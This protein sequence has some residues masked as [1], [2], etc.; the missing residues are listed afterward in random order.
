[1]PAGVGRNRGVEGISSQTPIVDL[2]SKV[3]PTYDRVGPRIFSHF[4]RRLVEMANMAGGAQVLDVATGR[5]A[6]LFPASDRVGPTGRV[7]GIDLVEGMVKETADEIELLGLKNAAMCQMDAEELK[8]PDAFF[9]VVLCGLSIFFFPRPE[10]ALS[11]FHR[12]MKTG[13]SVG[14]TT[15]AEERGGRGLSWMNEI[16]KPHLPQTE[17]QTGRPEPSAVLGTPDG[18]RRILFQAGFA[19]VRVTAEEADFIYKDEEEWWASL[20][21]HSIRIPLER[22]DTGTR[23]RFKD[24]FCRKIREFKRPD[25]IHHQRSVLFALGTKPLL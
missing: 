2:F 16:L 17:A 14:V 21:S 6:V 15:W 4:G 8:Y 19:D 12:V 23:E 22:M 24:D 25:G 5:G 1:M 9:D 10:Q 11:E 3:A 13:G 7:T 18:L 20:W